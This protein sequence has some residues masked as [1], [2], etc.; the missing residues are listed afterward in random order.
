MTQIPAVFQAKGFLMLLCDASFQ[1]RQAV[2]E[3]DSYSNNRYARASIIASVL[4]IE[5][6]ANSLL[7]S[8]ELPKKF[9]Q[10]LDKLPAIGKLETYLRIENKKNIDR[11]KSETQKVIELIKL[12]NDFVHPKIKKIESTIS[13]LTEDGEFLSL[14][15]SMMPD[16]WPALNIP[17]HS[18]FW[19]S[20]TAKIAVQALLEFYEYLFTELL[21][22]NNKEIEIHFFDSLQI[23]DTDILFCFDEVRDELNSLKNYGFSIGFI[24]NSLPN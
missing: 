9:L 22:M 6:C 2:K 23:G 11:G 4:S 13:P 10:E 20:D 24:E 7:T 14:P 12:R 21:E 18:M 8:L 5:S 19:S 15:F 16:K 1:L 3:K 17:K